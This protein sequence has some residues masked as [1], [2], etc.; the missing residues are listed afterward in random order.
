VLSLQTLVSE[1]DTG[2]VLHEYGTP[3]VGLVPSEPAHGTSR[4]P[5]RAHKQGAA[6]RGAELPR[7]SVSATVATAGRDPL[8]LLSSD[9]IWMAPVTATAPLEG[10]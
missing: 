5:A 10:C 2:G 8:L 4:H 6:P 7:N 3:T 9:A 1:G